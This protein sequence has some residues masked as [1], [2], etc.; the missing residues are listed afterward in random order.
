MSVR[1]RSTNGMATT[2]GVR[3]K[4]F[5][6]KIL[7][8]SVRVNSLTYRDELCNEDVVQCQQHKNLL[9]KREEVYA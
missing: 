3:S 8:S 2:C 9:S 6:K 4:Q 7:G 1:H 5:G